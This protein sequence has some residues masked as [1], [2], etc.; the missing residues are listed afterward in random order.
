LFLNSS[1]RLYGI[2]RLS[3]NSVNNNQ[4][5]II[6]RNCRVN[7]EKLATKRSKRSVCLFCDLFDCSK[8]RKNSSDVYEKDEKLTEKEEEG[9]GFDLGFSGIFWA[10]VGF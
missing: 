3:L 8:S 2:V 9:E 5:I 1:H 4:S 6:P 7:E 10:H